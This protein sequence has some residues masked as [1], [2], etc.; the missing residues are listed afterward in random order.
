MH[1]K[2]AFFQT[3]DLVFTI[4]YWLLVA[5]IL[6][7]WVSVDPYNPIIKFI[8]GVTEPILAPFRRL[9][10]PRPGMPF[11]ISPLFAFFALAI[12]KRIVYAILTPL[13][14]YL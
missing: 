10:P 7:S 11:D 6:L 12:L 3:I 13:L 8:Y 2:Y 1:L 4:V 9:F 5:R 14:Y